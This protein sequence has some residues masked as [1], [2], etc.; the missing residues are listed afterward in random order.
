MEGLNWQHA[1]NYM[2]EVA[3]QCYE[4]N[5]YQELENYELQYIARVVNE[6]FNT[7]FTDDDVFDIL[8]DFEQDLKQSGEWIEDETNA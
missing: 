1:V 4:E 2:I 7:T 6:K 3:Q 8:E 5:N